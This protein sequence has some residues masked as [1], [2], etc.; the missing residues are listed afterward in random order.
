M[1][2]CIQ[3]G[4]ET[5][6]METEKL[7]VNNSII[8]NKTETR[9]KTT[10]MME[11]FLAIKTEH[12]DCILF[13]RM[14]DFYELFF[15]DAV[16]A[17]ASLDITLT[18]RGTYDGKPIAMC[19]VPVHSSETYL[20]RLIKKGYR[21]AVCEQLE[22]PSEAKK[23]GAKSVVKR[24]VVRIVT[25][26]TITEETILDSKTNNYL[27]CISQLRGEMSIAWADISSRDFYVQ[28]VKEA[29]VLGV[30]ARIAP[31]E[32]LLPQKLLSHPDLLDVWNEYKAFLIPLPDARFDTVNAEKR[33]QDVFAVGALDS[34]GDFTKSN[35]S[36]SGTLLDYI[37]IT[38]V[39]KLPLIN[40]PKKVTAGDYMEID[41]ATRKSLE[42][43][44]TMSGSRKDSLLDIMDKTITGAGARLLSNYV[45]RPLNNVQQVESRL[46]SVDF[47]VKQSDVRE[48]MRNILKNIP[49]LDRALS[50]LSLGRGS[51]RD[52]ASIK[53]GLSQT[54]AM[55]LLLKSANGDLLK[56]T[57][58]NLG[59]HDVLVENLHNALEAELPST[60][61][62]GGVIRKGYASELDQI[63]LL[64]DE[65]RRVMATL[66]MKYRKISG[67]DSLKIKHN[68]V[69]Q[70]Y[71][72]ITARH[73]DKMIDES[74]IHRQTMKGA[75][76]FTTTELSELSRD[77][78]E[79]KD[80][81]L[82][83]EENI[84]K[85]LVVLVMDC[86]SAISDCATA[87]AKI[88]VFSALA[89]QAIAANWVCPEVNNSLDF[90]IIGGRHPVVEKSL[91][92]NDG[93]VFKT[94]DC[95]LQDK[96]YGKMWLLTGP[97]MAGK[98]T[99]L[100]QNALIS[101]LAQMGSFV[102]ADK[103]R[104]GLMDRIFSR[105]GASDDLAKGRST[106]MVEMVETA[107][108]LNQA[109]EKSLVILDE[110]GRGTATYDG[111]SIAWACVE[112]LCDTNKC[113]GLFATHYHELNA[114][115][116]TI[117]TLKSYSMAVKE[118]DGKVIFLHSVK[119]GCAEGSYGIYVAKL[120]GL[121][122][123]ALSRA[124]QVLKRLEHGNSTKMSAKDIVSDLPLF[125][126]G[127]SVVEVKASEVEEVLGSVNVDDMAPRDALDFVYRLKSILE[128]NK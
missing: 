68:N 59:L 71:I 77:V 87:I 45:S 4:Y 41:S 67:I 115:T 24:G 91:K 107:T 16:Q 31:K 118:W 116:D 35:I 40:R 78:L 128:K 72:E 75:I 22:D 48:K 3:R 126:A 8:A 38:Q 95:M 7:N 39:G 58:K 27:C 106:F 30:L 88:D 13:Y 99:F 61:N 26:G 101:I 14:G 43:T 28:S 73:A 119:K 124:E 108:I 36:A 32:I 21:V 57:A 84:F 12:S 111:L 74:F 93:A 47:F 83:L 98:S 2:A 110:I 63:R 20:L 69:L 100:R 114:L 97:N 102:P 76:R 52:L 117:D 90:E 112:Y 37:E 121:P 10:P 66:E 103:C 122:S 89:E 25:P 19:G 109:T 6:T 17:S 92:S 85:G 81:A 55:R 46:M 127:G 1:K 64:R 50:R 44:M 120:A 65:S 125:N 82:A 96:E 104:I 62:D 54:G 18:K 33:L 53:I 11:Q 42:I 86:A 29:D 56:N 51:P 34:F 80:K 15:E 5:M 60:L 94:N 113:R 9:I 23:R 49:D 123:A 79:A 105:V 70:Y